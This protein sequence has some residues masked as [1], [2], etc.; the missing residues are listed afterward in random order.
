MIATDK[1][2]TMVAGWLKPMPHLPVNGRKWLAENVWWIVIIWVALSGLAAITLLGAL[3]FFSAV[4]TGVAIMTDTIVYTGWFL[5]VALI[6]LA[7]MFAQL[8]LMIIAINPLKKF[9]IKGWKLMFMTILL[10]A[11][12]T[13]VGVVLN[14]NAG[15]I[16]SLATGAINFLIGAYL[17]LEIKSY[18]VKK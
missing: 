13:L 7:F 1:I 10:S 2:E 3:S 18:F 6:S 11:A 4:T 14:F 9:Q 12:G 5:F 15:S 8:V 16:M 17:L